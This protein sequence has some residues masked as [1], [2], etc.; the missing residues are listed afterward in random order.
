ML[1]I[2]EFLHVKKIAELWLIYVNKF[3]SFLIMFLHRDDKTKLVP[4]FLLLELLAVF[5]LNLHKY[6]VYIKCQVLH[7]VINVKTVKK[8]MFT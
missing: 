5:T 2:F 1:N 8:F 7:Y 3:F 6:D 4:A